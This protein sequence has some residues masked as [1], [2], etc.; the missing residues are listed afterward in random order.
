MSASVVTSFYLSLNS[1]VHLPLC[2]ILFTLCVLTV[3]CSL[4]ADSVTDHMSVLNV[5]SLFTPTSSSVLLTRPLVHVSQ[6][7]MLNELSR[8]TQRDEQCAIRCESHHL[9][10]C[11][12][13]RILIHCGSL[14][15][16]AM[17]VYMCVLNCA[18]CE[19]MQVLVMSTLLCTFID[20]P[21]V[22]ADVDSLR[23][24]KQ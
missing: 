21:S 11:R 5:S 7:Q 1:H 10:Q 24:R 15:Q 3:S 17:S 12:C 13:M 2:L 16:R 20:K 4:S 6:L 9:I 14:Q 22:T 19:P 8:L 23:H 18:R